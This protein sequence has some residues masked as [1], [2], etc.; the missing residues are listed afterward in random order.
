MKIA[1]KKTSA[2]KMVCN[3]LAKAKEYADYYLDIFA[4]SSDCVFRARIRD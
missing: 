3:A 1:D 4:G 2:E